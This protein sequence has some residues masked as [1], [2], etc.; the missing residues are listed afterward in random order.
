MKWQRE[1][2]DK[3]APGLCIKLWKMFFMGTKSWLAFGKFEGDLVAQVDLWPN[4]SF[5]AVRDTMTVATPIKEH[6]SLGIIFN[7]LSPLLSW[8]YARKHGTGEG[9]EGS[10]SRS[11]GKRR[12][13]ATVDI[14]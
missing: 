2:S 8:W 12:W 14:A 13:R 7:W 11:E 5:I 6:I 10:I 4:L 9:S 3:A 1:K